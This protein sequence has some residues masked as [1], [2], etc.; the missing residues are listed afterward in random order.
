MYIFWFHRSYLTFKGDN[1][2]YI[3]L[4][5]SIF[6]VYPIFISISIFDD[7][8]HIPFCCNQ[9][10]RGPISVLEDVNIHCFLS[11]SHLRFHS[12]KKTIHYRIWAFT[13]TN[14]LVKGLLLQSQRTPTYAWIQSIYNKLVQMGIFAFRM[15]HI[16]ENQLTPHIMFISQF[17]IDKL[18]KLSGGKQVLISLVMSIEK[19]LEFCFQTYLHRS[20]FPKWRPDFLSLIPK[21]LS[22]RC[23][24]CLI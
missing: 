13:S 6:I 19:S 12:K 1:N 3:S 17:F 10:F 21:S 9:L 22:R 5:L 2:I 14:S 8:A 23:Q 20:A 16:Q 7:W 11:L 18:V 15:L 4:S 24:E